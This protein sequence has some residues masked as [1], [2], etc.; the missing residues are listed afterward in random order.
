[1]GRVRE[2]SRDQGDPARLDV[3]GEPELGA[4]QGADAQGPGATVAGERE[5][6]VRASSEDRA[7]A[8]LAE[9]L[10]RTFLL[11]GSLVGAAFVATVLSFSVCSIWLNSELEDWEQTSLADAVAHRTELLA[12][13]LNYAIAGGV[14]LE[15]AICASLIL[16]AFRQHRLLQDAIVAPVAALLRDIGRVR[17]GELVTTI[18]RSGP[19]ELRE[20]GVG[21]ND[22][23]RALAVARGLAESRDTVVRQHANRLRQILDASREFSESLNLSYVVRSVSSST[24][25]VGGYDQV[26]VWLM[27]DDQKGLRQA[28]LTEAALVLDET[29]DDTLAWRAA[30]S[31]RMTFEG[32]DGR[33][34]FGDGGAAPVHARAVPLVVGTRVV[35]A[36]EARHVEACAS[37]GEAVEIL[38]MLASHAATALES[39]RVNQIAE[40]K[41]LTDP[42]TRLNNRRRLEE[43]LDDECN[44]CARYGR[45]LAFVMLDVDNFKAFNDTHGHSRADLALQEVATVIGATVRTT[46]SAYRYGGEEFCVL[47]RET[48]AENAMHFAE[49]LRERIEARFADDTAPRITASF[50]VAEVSGVTA[51]PRALLEAADAAMYESKRTGRNRVVLSTPLPRDSSGSIA[52]A[53]PVQTAESGTVAKALTVKTSG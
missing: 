41:S 50:G 46:D 18:P 21:L 29:R 26:V 39:A 22:M 19:S 24:M 49:R 9:Q 6:G 28:R 44:R 38:V 23:V 36:L 1:M 27:A 32:L 11:I 47:L 53:S 33:I 12:R 5:S 4:H 31:G 10:R 35:G 45:P 13:R 15:L 8:S 3:A 17:D 16:L 34:Q 48:G 25:A 52:I 2:G 51:T 42:L 7:P 20:L 37:S 43:D 14:A 30:K 40:E